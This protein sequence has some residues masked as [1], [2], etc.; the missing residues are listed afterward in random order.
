MKKSKGL[1]ALEKVA[2]KCGVSVAEVCKEI[3]SAI[4]TGMA[5]PDPTARA[6]WDK[7]MKSGRKP[8]PEEFIAYMAENSIP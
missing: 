4:D 2:L 3:E 6:F 1:K 5:N 8:T 7:Y